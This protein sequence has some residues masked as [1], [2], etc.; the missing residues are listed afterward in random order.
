M[1]YAIK[2][3]DSY[4]VSLKYQVPLKYLQ[5]RNWFIKVCNMHSAGVRLFMHQGLPAWAL[6]VKEVSVLLVGSKVWQQQSESRRETVQPRVKSAW[7]EWSQWKQVI[8][9]SWKTL[10]KTALQSKAPNENEISAYFI[11]FKKYLFLL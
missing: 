5:N 8:F 7:Y 11:I 3:R 10:N 9:W 4:K 6:W 1:V 2:K